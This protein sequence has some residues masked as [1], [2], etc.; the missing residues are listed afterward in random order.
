MGGQRQ[1][2][3]EA[4]QT[5]FAKNVV[6]LTLQPLTLSKQGGGFA[7]YMLSSGWHIILK[8]ST[9]TATSISQITYLRRCG[10]IHSS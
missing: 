5:F 1:P 6:G 7:L 9:S 8:C 4:A 10:R 3:Q 2:A